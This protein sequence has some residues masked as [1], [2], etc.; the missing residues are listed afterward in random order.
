MCVRVRVNRRGK[1]ACKHCLHAARCC[2]CSGGTAVGQG[3]WV[4]PL[5]SAQEQRSGGRWSPPWPWRQPAAPCSVSIRPSCTTVARSRPRESKSDDGGH[6]SA[7][8]HVAGVILTARSGRAVVH[9]RVHQAGEQRQQHCVSDH[10][11]ALSLEQSAA[12][13]VITAFRM[14]LAVLGTLQAGAMR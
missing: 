13:P 1:Q 9:G 7:L 4:L 11:R 10:S 6:S 12:G 3:G 2:I 8:P 5:A 14:E